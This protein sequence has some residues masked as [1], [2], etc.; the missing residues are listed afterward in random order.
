MRGGFGRAG[1]VFDVVTLPLDLQKVI[2]KMRGDFG[3]RLSLP[4]GDTEVCPV[5]RLSEQ[6]EGGFERAVSR[7]FAC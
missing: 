6:D 1:S 2:N 3:D 7:L 5:C 4:R